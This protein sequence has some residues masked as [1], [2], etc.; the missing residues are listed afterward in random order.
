MS[1]QATKDDATDAASVTESDLRR[2]L[3]LLDRHG[4]TGLPEWWPRDTPPIG[5]VFGPVQAARIA[6]WTRA[7]VAGGE[8]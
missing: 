5:R 2:R 4:R 1:A 6:G 3:D 8:R 7:V